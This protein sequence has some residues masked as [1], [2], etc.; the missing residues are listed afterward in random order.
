M[1]RGQGMFPSSHPAPSLS[2]LLA[3][4]LV[5]LRC[6]HHVPDP[7]GGR[8]LLRL[9]LQRPHPLLRLELEALDS[10]LLRLRWA[11]RT[12]RPSLPLCH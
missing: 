9:L 5:E 8:L 4:G 11:R 3:L 6:L 1:S 10:L 2:C 12:V 7:L